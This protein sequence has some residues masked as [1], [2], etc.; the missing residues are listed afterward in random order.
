MW[1]CPKCQREFEKPNQWHSCGD[2]SI[3]KLLLGKTEGT[4]KLFHHLM[5]ILEDVGEVEFEPVQTAIKVNRQ[6]T[7]FAMIRILKNSINMEIVLKREVEDFPILKA[8]KF[9]K[10]DYVHYLKFYDRGDI[11][12]EIIS[13]INEAYHSSKD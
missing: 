7:L 13:W 11:T 3:D 4:I 6:R 9:S 2:F 12:H 8:V 5:K 1:T 10:T